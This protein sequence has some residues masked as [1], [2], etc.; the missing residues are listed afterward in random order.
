MR[1]LDKQPAGSDCGRTS[2]RPV[3]A[4]AFFASILITGN[5]MLAEGAVMNAIEL[6]N[7][8]EADACSDAM[9][10]DNSIDGALRAEAEQDVSTSCEEKEVTSLLL[11]GILRNVLRLDRYP[12]LC[13]VLRFLLGTT[14]Q[15]CAHQLRLDVRR[16]DDFQSRRCA[17]SRLLRDCKYLNRSRP[18]A[19][20]G[21]VSID[22][23]RRKKDE[24]RSTRNQYRFKTEWRRLCGMSGSSSIPTNQPNSRL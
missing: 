17:S 18:A 24:K 9:F 16:V 15:T 6:L 12:R 21:R 11:P 8:D 23:R 7:A 22:I 10:F 4:R 1:T 19:A 20:T 14:R 2:I 13:F 3:V 5:Q